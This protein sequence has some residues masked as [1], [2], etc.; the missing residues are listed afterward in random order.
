MFKVCEFKKNNKLSETESL[1]MAFASLNSAYLL[2]F[3][4]FSAKAQF[5]ATH[6]F[7]TLR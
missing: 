2:Q 3:Y 1:N 5:A 6:F 7:T 4:P